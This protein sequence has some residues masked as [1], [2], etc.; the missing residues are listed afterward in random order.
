MTLAIL[1]LGYA[2]SRLCLGQ[3]NSRAFA[4][5][6]H[7]LLSEIKIFEIFEVS[8][9]RFAGIEAFGAP[10]LLGKHVEPLLDFGIQPECQHSRPPLLYRY[11]RRTSFARLRHE[12]GGEGGLK[13]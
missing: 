9:N 3:R 4:E 1:I 12:G 13:D 5:A 6:L 7:T 10:G 2:E 8:F 11:S